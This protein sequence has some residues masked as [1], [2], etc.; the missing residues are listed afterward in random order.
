M[1][2][3]LAGIASFNNNLY[4]R[5]N[6]LHKVLPELRISLVLVQPIIFMAVLDA[7]VL[8]YMASAVREVGRYTSYAYAKAGK[9]VKAKN[10]LGW[11]GCLL[12]VSDV[13]LY[14]VECSVTNT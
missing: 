13:H 8:V 10:S 7:V 1:Q 2:K 6:N 12:H 5:D 14:I 9:E 4:E 3:L 11:C